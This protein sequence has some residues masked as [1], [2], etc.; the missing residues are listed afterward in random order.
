MPD[1]RP[2]QF[3]RPFGTHNHFLSVNGFTLA[4]ASLYDL[5]NHRRRKLIEQTSM[6]ACQIDQRA[7]ST[8]E[9]YL[10][11][12]GITRNQDIPHTCKWTLFHC[13]TSTSKKL[14]AASI[15]TLLAKG[16]STIV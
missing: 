8:D 3:I 13:T 12:I 2:W 10:L 15:S 14:Y 1:N 16:V 4:P 6:Q 5:N 11:P 7:R 9:S